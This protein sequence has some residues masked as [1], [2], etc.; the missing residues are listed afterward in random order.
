MLARF[1]AGAGDSLKVSTGRTLCYVALAT[2][3]FACAAQPAPQP[4]QSRSTD[5]VIYVAAQDLPSECY[6]T[7]GAVTVEEPYAD[8]SIDPDNSGAA[9]QLS[10]L[11]LNKYPNDV[12]AV[13]NVRSVQ[14]DAGTSVTVIGD[15]IELEDRPTVECVIRKMP[16]AIDTAAQMSAGAMAGTAIAGPL[17][18]NV[19]DAEAGA[20]IGGGAVG[21]YLLTKK[22]QE[23][24]FQQAQIINGLQLQRRDITRLLA[25][26]SRLRECEEQELSLADCNLE[27][28][29]AAATSANNGVES[30]DWKASQF[31]LQKQIQEQQ[32]YINQ[33]RQQVIDIRHRLRANR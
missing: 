22:Q 9:K 13:I 17:G 8:A 18:G 10:T 4:R 15:A 5:R 29:A 19:S 25:E 32:D 12:D 23:E 31:Q 14:N 6:H 33:L 21:K 1:T 7:L 24:R 28:T 16:G 11:A 30:N 3:A 26:R 27:K 20:L 2:T